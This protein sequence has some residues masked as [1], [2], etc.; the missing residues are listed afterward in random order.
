MKTKYGAKKIR[1]HNIN[2]RSHLELYCYECLK[3]AKIPFGYETNTYILQEGFEYDSL[4]RSG[5]VMRSKKKLRPITYTPD[6]IGQNFIIETKG[7]RTKDFDIKWKLFKYY[8]YK[9]NI[10]MALY[11]P[12]NKKEIDLCLQQILNDAMA[13]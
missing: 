6:F 11:M 2:F 7:K 1:S 10:K 9:N 13:T 8:L 3:S 12:T 4:E 5:K